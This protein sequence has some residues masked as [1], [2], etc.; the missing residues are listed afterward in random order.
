MHFGSRQGVHEKNK[1]NQDR[2]NLTAYMYD[3]LD[4]PWELQY[5]Q[6][7]P[8]LIGDIRGEV[9]E[10]WVGTGRH[11]NYYSA[12]VNLTAVDFS[13]SMLRHAMTRV[14]GARCI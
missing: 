5:R 6:W 14:R 4:F 10:A 13:P 7:R 12:D 11:L 9:I 1:A 2:Y 8:D 3:I